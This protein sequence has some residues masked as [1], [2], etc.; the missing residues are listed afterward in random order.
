MTLGVRAVLYDGEGRVF[1]V[2]HSYV[3]GWHLPGG[4]VEPGQSAEEA[5]AIELAEEGNFTLTEPP[6]LFGV[7]L[8]RQATPRDHVLL[9]R[10]EKALQAGPRAPDHEIVETGFFAP[11]ALPEGTTTG[12]R[13]RLA[14][15]F[16]HAPRSAEW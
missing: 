11:N 13:R 10:V 7:Y 5:L 2:R 12:T 6:V 8:N 4:G 9:Y 16:G 15:V 3:P 14:E 1:L